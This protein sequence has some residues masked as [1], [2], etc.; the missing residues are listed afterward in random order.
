MSACGAG[1]LLA[2]YVTGDSL[3]S[4]AAAFDLARYDDPQYQKKL[5][6]WGQ[7]GQL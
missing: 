5:A 4:Y 7:N 3:P 6:E 1:E 2:R